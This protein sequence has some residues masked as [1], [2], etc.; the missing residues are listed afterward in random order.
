MFT[1]QARL[2]ENRNAGANGRMVL[3]IRGA[4]CSLFETL[5]HLIG[6]DMGRGPSWSVDCTCV[7]YTAV[8]LSGLTWTWPFASEAV[9][10]N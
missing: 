5:D 8:R 3:W 2:P 7:S 4:A 6:G 9:G 1:R 10:Q